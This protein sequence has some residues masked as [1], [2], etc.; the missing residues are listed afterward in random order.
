MPIWLSILVL[1]FTLKMYYRLVVLGVATRMWSIMWNPDCDT[2][3]R[4]IFPSQVSSIWSGTEASPRCSRPKQTHATIPLWIV[5]GGAAKMYSAPYKRQLYVCRFPYLVKCILSGDRTHGQSYSESVH[6][7]EKGRVPG[8]SHGMRCSLDQREWTTDGII[9]TSPDSLTLVDCVVP[10]L[11]FHVSSVGG[12]QGGSWLVCVMLLLY[13]SCVRND[14]S[15]VFGW[16]RLCF[17]WRQN[18]DLPQQ[19][20]SP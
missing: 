17:Q 3:T 4:C 2:R 12:W 6:Y 13:W 14:R 8:F 5:Y 20:M 1:W 10:W 11:F 16:T 19:I 15:L 18:S 9:T 7:N